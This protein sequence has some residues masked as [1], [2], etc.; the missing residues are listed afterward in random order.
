MKVRFIDLNGPTQQIKKEYIRRVDAF[1]DKANFILTEEVAEFENKWAKYIGVEHCVG[2]SNGADALWLALKAVGV[3]EGDEVI[4]Q[5]N[6]YN[7][8][9][10]SIL[11]AGAIPRFVDIDPA[12]LLINPALVERMITPKTK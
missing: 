1:L 6:A 11:R 5:G 12:T 7:A 10:T 3:G 2:V 4:T 9:V 8:S